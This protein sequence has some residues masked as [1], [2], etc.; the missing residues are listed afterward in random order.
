MPGS[1]WVATERAPRASTPR[2]TLYPHPHSPVSAFNYVRS[3]FRY[4]QSLLRSICR[5][6]RMDDRPRRQKFGVVAAA[7][8]ALAAVSIGAAAPASAGTKLSVLSQA[9]P[10]IAAGHAGTAVYFAEHAPSHPAASR[11]RASSQHPQAQHPAPARVQQ[12]AKAQHPVK[13]KQA[14]AVRPDH[15][16][17]GRRPAVRHEVRRE[18]R[19]AVRR[20]VRHAVRR[21]VRHV[22]KR[23][24]RPYNIYDSIHP[25]AFPAHRVVAT[26]ATGNYAA[27]P[28]QV[29]GQKKVM[30]IDITGRDYAA[31]ILDVEP[32]DATPAGAAA[33]AEHRLSSNPHVLARIYTMRSE[34]A[35][36][37]QAVSTLKA[38][39]RA[40]IRWWIADPTGVDHMVPG[41][42]ATQWYWGPSYDVTTANPNF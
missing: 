23:I 34:W 26:Y 24:L 22:V 20:A 14:D 9:G 31:S 21:A 41:S 30:W 28:E 19:H 10:A 1:A 38:S 25:S 32:G 27:Q 13:A 4:S 11:P 17:P 40:R 8:A 42:S 16:A 39:M 5:R 37:Q 2:L 3:L 36:V 6:C 29:A 12:P 15:S 18:V 7:L 33:W 35:A